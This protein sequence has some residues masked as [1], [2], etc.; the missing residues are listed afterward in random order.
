MLGNIVRQHQRVEVFLRFIR[1]IIAERIASRG[2]AGVFSLQVFS[3]PLRLDRYQ[4]IGGWIDIEPSQRVVSVIVGDIMFDW[5][6]ELAV[7][8]IRLFDLHRD[9]VTGHGQKRF[10]RS[11]FFVP[12]IRSAGDH[13][14]NSSAAVIICSSDNAHTVRHFIQAD[15]QAINIVCAVLIIIPAVAPALQPAFFV[16]RVLVSA[17]DVL[18]AVAAVCALP[19]NSHHLVPFKQRRDLIP[20]TDVFVGD[21]QLVG[22]VVIVKPAV[23]SAAREQQHGGERKGAHR[24]PAVH[25]VSPFIVFFPS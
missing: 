1:A 19:Y 5:K 9:T 25:F 8:L 12:L 14:G 17:L 16:A 10:P 13:T 2:K 21:L 15:I 23:A 6:H 4:V 24:S 20:L 3:V 18:T 11:T 22:A 7:L